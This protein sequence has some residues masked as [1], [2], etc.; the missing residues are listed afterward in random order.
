MTCPDVAARIVE[1]LD[2]AARSGWQG[3]RRNE[4]VWSFL[5]GSLATQ[6]SSLARDVSATDLDLACELRGLAHRTHAVAGRLADVE[7]VR[8]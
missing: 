6:L 8:P 1:D 4:P 2:A 5:A 3:P 7:E